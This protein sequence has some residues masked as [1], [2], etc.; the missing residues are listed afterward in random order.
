MT[1]YLGDIVLKKEMKEL[2]I[3]KSNKDFLASR[4]IYK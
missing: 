2:L 3:F 4:S 1:R